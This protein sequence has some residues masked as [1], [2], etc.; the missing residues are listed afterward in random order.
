MRPPVVPFA[1]AFALALALPAGC[2]G[3]EPEVVTEGAEAVAPGL[4]PDPELPPAGPDVLDGR[5]PPEWAV[6]DWWRYRDG[7]GNEVGFAVVAASPAGYVTM[8]TAA[9]TAAYDALSDVSYVGPITRDLAGAQHGAP[10]AFFRW[11]LANG[12]TWSTTWDGFELELVATASPAV[13]VPGGTA[14]GF[15]IVG[16]AGSRVHVA[17]SYAP[18]VGFWSTI[19]FDNGSFALELADFGRNFTGDVYAGEARELAR[20]EAAA[21]PGLAPYWEFAVDEE[22]LLLEVEL[23]ATATAP[24]LARLEVAGPAGDDLSAQGA[25]AALGGCKIALRVQLTPA[26]GVG[27]VIQASTMPGAHAA[28][29]RAAYATASAFGALA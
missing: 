15:E 12:T 14:A 4:R 6:G 7:A 22:P 21:G 11:P 5:A 23:E 2:L 1:L 24:G 19:S 25:C 26:A 3:R 27:K 18:V 17:Y 28:V 8:A 10:V 29:A 9:S 16:T 13:P 20:V